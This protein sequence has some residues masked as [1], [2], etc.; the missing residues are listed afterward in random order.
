MRDHI[1]EASEAMQTLEKIIKTMSCDVPTGI[2]VE[3]WRQID[4]TWKHFVV[5]MEIYFDNIQVL[6]KDC[7]II[8]NQEL[9]KIPLGVHDVFS[10]DI[11]VNQ[12]QNVR[13]DT[14]TEERLK[15]LCDEHFD[16]TLHDTPIHLQKLIL[17]FYEELQ[18]C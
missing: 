17:M 13:R 2:I 15:H 8:L 14:S 11:K 7:K 16:D 5:A 9:Q 3:R 6:N 12:R 4:L 10:L 1:F 18:N